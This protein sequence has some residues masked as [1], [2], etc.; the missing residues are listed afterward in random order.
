MPRNT[1]ATGQFVLP[2][3]V[4]TSAMAAAKPGFIPSSGPTT[5]PKV[6]PT[7]NVGTISPPL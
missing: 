7:K 1:E 4:A 3:K 6:A 5:Q 2:Q